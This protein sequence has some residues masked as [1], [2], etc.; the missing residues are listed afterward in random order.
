MPDTN[1]F[2]FAHYREEFTL[3]FDSLRELGLS[4]HSLFAAAAQA[5]AQCQQ[6]FCVFALVG[7]G[8]I[9]GEV[10]WRFKAVSS[11]MQE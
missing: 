1:I 4:D 6:V 5:K 11:A 10:V 7:V 9:I 2:E 8:V 3:I